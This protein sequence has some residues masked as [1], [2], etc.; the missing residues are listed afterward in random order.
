MSPPPRE[1]S[2]SSCFSESEPKG[3]VI[4]ID[5]VL[6][7]MSF[8]LMGFFKNTNARFRLLWHHRSSHS[9]FEALYKKIENIKYKLCF[10][11]EYRLVIRFTRS[12]NDS[13]IGKSDPKENNTKYNRY[14]LTAVVS[15]HIHSRFWRNGCGYFE[16]FFFL[17]GA[18][19]TTVTPSVAS[20]KSRMN[21]TAD[22]HGARRQHAHLR[23]VYRRER[24]MG[25]LEPP[26]PDTWTGQSVGDGSSNFASME[27]FVTHLGSWADSNFVIWINIYL[28][29][30]SCYLY[31]RTTKATD[32]KIQRNF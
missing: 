7:T 23:G 11:L 12:F 28:Q 20:M 3:S 9:Y 26:W 32:G 2:I 30:A 31:T 15:L 18:H 19:K 13:H 29:I 16:F 25:P 1:D 8:V 17:L 21:K 5:H 22:W 24:E 10:N 4:F 6:W 27:R 14:L